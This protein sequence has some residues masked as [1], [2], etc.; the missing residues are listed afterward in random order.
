[1]RVLTANSNYSGGW[2]RRRGNSTQTRRYRRQT[3]LHPLRDALEGTDVKVYAGEAVAQ[4]AAGGDS[5]VAVNALVGYAG[6]APT[7]AAPERAGETRA[8]EQESL[9]WAANT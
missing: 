6:L 9:S 3:I 1:M 2:R 8:G 4:V 7:V 5:D